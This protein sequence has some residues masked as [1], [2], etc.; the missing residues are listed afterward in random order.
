ME[1]LILNISIFANVILG[2]DHEAARVHEHA[3]AT[4][5]DSD[6]DSEM[7]VLNASLKRIPLLFSSIDYVWVCV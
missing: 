1:V 2:V 7:E 4:L 3:E 6:Y 5:E